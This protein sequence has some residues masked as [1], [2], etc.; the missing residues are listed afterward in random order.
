M[1]LQGRLHSGWILNLW[2]CKVIPSLWFVRLWIVFFWKEW[3]GLSHN[4]ATVARP[5]VYVRRGLGKSVCASHVKLDHLCCYFMAFG[6]ATLPSNSLI[7]VD[8]SV[9]DSRSIDGTRPNIGLLAVS[10][11]HRT[12]TNANTVVCLLSAIL[13]L[14]L[15][16][17]LT[18]FLKHYSAICLRQTRTDLTFDNIYSL[19]GLSLDMPS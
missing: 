17:T 13:W 2:H 7:L 16:R 19:M 12:W 5:C 8:E 4:H 10:S 3:N 1:T 6:L 14:C 18:I 15:L 9:P 11:Q